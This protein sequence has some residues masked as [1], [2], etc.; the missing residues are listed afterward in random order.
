MLEASLL[1]NFVHRI[2]ENYQMVVGILGIA[3]AIKVWL[4]KLKLP[5]A[6]QRVVGDRNALQIAMDAVRAAAA[7]AG[8]TDA[9]RREYAVAFLRR[10]LQR[11]LSLEVADSVANLVVEF[12]W[13]KVKAGKQ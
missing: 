6:V 13:A 8:K 1:G 2:T 12:A 3:S 5:P 7:L 4:S 11:A 10:E 9:E